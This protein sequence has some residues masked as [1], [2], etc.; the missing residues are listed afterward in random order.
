MNDVTSFRAFFQVRDGSTSDPITRR[1]TP[2]RNKDNDHDTG[3]RTGTSSGQGSH[4]HR[5][6]LGHR[7]S[8]RQAVRGRRRQGRRRRPPRGRTGGVHTDTYREM[9]E[10]PDKTSFI[11]NLHALKRVPKPEELAR[12]VLCLA[13]DDAA[14]VTGTASL[15]D[16]GASI[17]RT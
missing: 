6:K 7:P 8:H 15:V 14:F 17:T 9:K 5:R 12:S 2:P 16:G 11:T 3:N 10:K 1:S 13:S 4:R